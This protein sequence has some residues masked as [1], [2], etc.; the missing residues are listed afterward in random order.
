M[1][2]ENNIALEEL[3]VNKFDNCGSALNLY[4]KSKGYFAGS[5]FFEYICQDSFVFFNFFCN[6]YFIKMC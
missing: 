3:R 1:D 2:I 4:R 6:Y 5:I